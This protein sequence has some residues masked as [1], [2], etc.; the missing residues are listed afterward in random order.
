MTRHPNGRLLGLKGQLQ[1]NFT[2]YPTNDRVTHKGAGE[3]ALTLPVGLV[4]DSR[5]QKENPI[6]KYKRALT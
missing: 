1:W 4:R 5:G 2:L 6:T 3:L